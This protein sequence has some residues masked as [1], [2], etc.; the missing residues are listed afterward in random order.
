MLKIKFCLNLE[1]L[2]WNYRAAKIL[3]LWHP[4]VYVPKPVHICPR[5]GNTFRQ[6][7]VKHDFQNFHSKFN[8]CYDLNIC[9]LSPY[10][11][12]GWNPDIQYDG[13][14]RWG[15][16]QVIRSWGGAL[17]VGIPESLALFTWQM[18]II[19]QTTGEEEYQGLDAPKSC[20]AIV[21][22]LLP[23]RGSD[24]AAMLT[25][26]FQPLELW[27]INFYSVGKEST[28]DAGDSSS[29]PGLGRSIRE[30]IGC[31]LQ[32]SWASLVAQL[33][34]NPPAMRETWVWLLDWED[35]VEKGKATHSSILA[36]RIPWTV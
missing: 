27:E 15:L 4:Q 7:K 26:D 28:C 3:H 6:K 24:L 8:E 25:L 33:V 5:G 11:F 12:T 9:V 23:R 13:V 18:L 14:R 30:G 16:W 21:R 34:K 1:S 19:Q 2:V 29:I 32:Y 10:K 17:L 20:E 22:S 35:P 31:P 36:W